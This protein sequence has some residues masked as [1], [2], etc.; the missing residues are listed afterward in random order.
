MM[1]SG[2]I[3]KAKALMREDDIVDQME[4]DYRSSHI[5][6]LGEG[7]CLAEIGVLYLDI[8]AN[9]ERIADHANN[10]AEA[11]ADSVLSG[12]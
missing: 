3:S 12:E 9:L 5:K 2:D 4:K 11:I 10:L 7:V 1:E 6:R 8:V